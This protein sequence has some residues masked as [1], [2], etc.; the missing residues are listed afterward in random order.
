MGLRFLRKPTR[1]AHHCTT[2]LKSNNSN[3]D[4]RRIV[5]AWISGG[6]A[7]TE[8]TQTAVESKNNE[9]TNK[10]TLFFDLDPVVPGLSTRDVDQAR[11]EVRGACTPEDSGPA[12]WVVIL[13][14]GKNNFEKNDRIG[15]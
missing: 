1:H 9:T 11:C 8:V 12:D 14:P 7:V 4:R 2:S 15:A 3:G 10:R 13:P 5:T 6:L